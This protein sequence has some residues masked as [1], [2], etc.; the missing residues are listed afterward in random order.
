M[1]SG[2][3]EKQPTMSRPVPAQASEKTDVF[4]RIDFETVAAFG[5]I[6]CGMRR[7]RFDRAGCAVRLRSGR[8]IRL[9]T[10]RALRQ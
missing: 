3:E 5:K 9:D 2:W 10:P 8:S 1:P 6:A 7:A 4:G